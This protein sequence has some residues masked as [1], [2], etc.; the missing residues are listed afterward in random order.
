MLAWSTASLPARSHPRSRASCFGSHR[1]ESDQAAPRGDN[2]TVEGYLRVLRDGLD[3]YVARTDYRDL[4]LI[5]HVVAFL[6]DGGRGQDDDSIPGEPWLYEIANRERGSGG[7]LVQT[8][9]G[10]FTHKPIQRHR[11]CVFR[12]GTRRTLNHGGGQPRAGAGGSRA[13]R[14]PGPL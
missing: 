4:A 1:P 6:G 5:V 12:R 11:P 3:K 13:A 2:R 10:R 8:P 7:R 9:K 14:H